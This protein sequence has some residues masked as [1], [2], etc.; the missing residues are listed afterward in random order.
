MAWTYSVAPTF[1]DRDPLTR[2]VMD[3]TRTGVTTRKVTSDLGDPLTRPASIPGVRSEASQ[4][5]RS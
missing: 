3:R 5:S 1:A 4:M 2:A